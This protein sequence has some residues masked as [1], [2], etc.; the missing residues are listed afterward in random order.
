M[1]FRSHKGDFIG[2]VKV[3]INNDDMDIELYT[4]QG[5]LINKDSLSKGEQQLYAS[6]LLK[7]LVEESG[8]KF[9]VF[10]DSPLQ[11]FDKSHASKIITDFYPSI[12]S[13]VILFPLLYKELTVDELN[14]IKPLINECFMIENDVNSSHF[15]SVL[16]DSLI[17]PSHVYT[18]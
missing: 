15:K 5:T 2:K 14:L 9:P 16:I 6:S 17:D 7:A 1:L 10:I 3:N 18:N 13:Q 12:S 8:I 11:K 4:P